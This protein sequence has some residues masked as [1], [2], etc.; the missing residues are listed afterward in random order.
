M[1]T[2][3]FGG[4]RERHYF[5]VGK[6]HFLLEG[7]SSDHSMKRAASPTLYDA[8]KPLKI[9]L[10][11]ALALNNAFSKIFANLRIQ[12]NMH[13]LSHSPKPNSPTSPTII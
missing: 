7:S 4:S 8:D 12:V 9:G 5:F 2:A 3:I 1:A 6:I 13:G 11:D 10:S